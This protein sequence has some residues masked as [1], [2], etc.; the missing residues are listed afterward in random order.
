MNYPENWTPLQE[1]IHLSKYSRWD[2]K[3]NRRESWGETVDRWYGW[4]TERASA[5]GVDLSEWGYD[6]RDMV[7]NLEVM[8][9]MRSLMTAGP[10]ADRDN[11]CIYNCSYL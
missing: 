1:Y 8:P 2:P 10:A 11:T 9:S 6:L 5:A 4:L 7:Y 3:K